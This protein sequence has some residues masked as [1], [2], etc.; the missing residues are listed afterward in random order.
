MHRRRLMGD[1]GALLPVIACVGALALGAAGAAQEKPAEAPA[2]PDVSGAWTGTWTVN[3]R[4]GAAPGMRLD[5]SVVKK[6]GG[7]FE[8]TFQGEC[9]RPYKYTV[10]M[11]G[12]QAGKVVLFKGTADLGKEDGGVYDWIGR[13]NGDEFLGFF[14]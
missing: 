7:K 3:A 1:L 11:E 4:G 2:P 13:A 8:A 14:T 6:R 10:K 5:A 12:R 9:G